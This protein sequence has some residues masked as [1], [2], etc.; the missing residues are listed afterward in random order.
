M[1]VAVRTINIEKE[2]AEALNRFFYHRKNFNRDF[3]MVDPYKITDDVIAELEGIEGVP[4][5]FFCMDQWESFIE[6]EEFPRLRHFFTRSNVGFFHYPGEYAKIVTLIE[7]LERDK[8]NYSAGVIN[9]FWKKQ[10]AQL[11]R[12]AH[13][14]RPGY[15]G[16][17][18]NKEYC[19]DVLGLSGDW[20]QMRE[21]LHKLM[22]KRID[23]TDEEIASRSQTILP[24]TYV[25]VD[26]TL[27]IDGE[28][29]QSLMKYLEKLSST[30][31][32]VIYTGGDLIDNIE[33]LE[34]CLN[35]P[36]SYSRKCYY[37]GYRLED[38]IDDEGMDVLRQRYM[39]FPE[40][41][42]HPDEIK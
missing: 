10:Y 9:F 35:F 22:K 16:F 1:G 40:K 32:V 41:C 39:I 12:L 2:V 29:N 7:D 21:Q 33:K 36:H 28:I 13:D 5:V 27:I 25:D 38:A 20:E 14:L 17:D 37:A 11:S 26:G 31:N 6:C 15:P 23:L 18:K 30:K 3:V 4:I 19:R 42:I 34:G 8:V 24:G